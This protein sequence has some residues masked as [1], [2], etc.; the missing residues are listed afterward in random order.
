MK[1]QWYFMI[2]MVIFGAVGIFARY[3]DCSSRKIAFYLALIGAVF[4][5][6]TVIRKKRTVSWH[7]LRRN[8]RALILSG[9]AL[10]GN[11]IFLFQAYKETTI[12]N[13]ALSY[14]SAPIQ[15]MVFSAILLQERLSKKKI[16]GVAVAFLG[17]TILLQQGAG[18]SSAHHV[19]GIF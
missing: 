16:A 15:V 17:L 2:S 8:R 10:S 4:W 9:V 1:E 11:W 13:A 7:Q 18:I 14:Y 12:A 5:L 3:I 19:L 6:V